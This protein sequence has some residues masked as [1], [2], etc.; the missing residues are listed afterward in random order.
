MQHYDPEQPPNPEAWLALDESER[1]RLVERY[2][3]QAGFELP[4]ARLH[5]T[6]HAVI[7]NQLARGDPAAAP[8][9]LQRLR[10][11]GLTRHEALHAI[12]SVLAQ[13]ICNVLQPGEVTGDAQ[14]RYAADL[15][16]LTADLWRQMFTEDDNA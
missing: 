9:A 5:A 11:E 8:R 1:I 16:A 15:E 2:H 3:R 12:G 13:H 7:E 14:A 10:R 6:I 4:N